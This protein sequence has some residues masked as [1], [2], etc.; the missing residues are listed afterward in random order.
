MYGI[1]VLINSHPPPP[2]PLWHSPGTCP[3]PSLAPLSSPSLHHLH[4]THIYECLLT[5][6]AKTSLFEGLCD[7]LWYEP[8]TKINDIN[9]NSTTSK[10]KNKNKKNNKKRT[11]TTNLNEFYVCYVLLGWNTIL[12]T[13][14]IKF[15]INVFHSDNLN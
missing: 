12:I 9:M 8:T 1:S 5:N 3:A 2:C 13:L 11:K 6:P 14:L 7:T 15:Y 10:N 4:N